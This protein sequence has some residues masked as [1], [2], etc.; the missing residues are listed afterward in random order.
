[1]FETSTFF[2]RCAQLYRGYGLSWALSFRMAKRSVTARRAHRSSVFPSLPTYV[3]F[4]D[5]PVER[6]KHVREG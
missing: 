5:T 1:M 6:E 4:L 3:E 2:L